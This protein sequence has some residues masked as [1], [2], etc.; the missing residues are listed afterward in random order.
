MNV[1][2]PGEGQTHPFWIIIGV[3]V[4]MLGGMLGYFKY[5]RWL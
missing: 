4:A 1:H 5:R 3:M 2:V